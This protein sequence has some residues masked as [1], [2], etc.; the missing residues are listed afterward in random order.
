MSENPICGTLEGRVWGPF[1]G[2]F[3]QMCI[4]WSLLADVHIV[5]TR[6]APWR[7]CAGGVQRRGS[8]LHRLI[9]GGATSEQRRDARLVAICAGEVQRHE[10][11]NRL[12]HAVCNEQDWDGVCDPMLAS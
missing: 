1:R 11:I 12:V 4:L 10:A 5:A 2:P 6:L 9:D 8:V 3:W 7:P